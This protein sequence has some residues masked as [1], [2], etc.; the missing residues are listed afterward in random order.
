MKKTKKNNSFLNV[1]LKHSQAL[2]NKG[3]F[4]PT[5]NLAFLNSTGAHRNHLEI[6][7]ELV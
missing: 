5:S 3:F 1:L 6:T 7:W 2:I 4:F